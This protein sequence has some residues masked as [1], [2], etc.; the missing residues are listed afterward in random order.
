MLPS[1]LMTFIQIFAISLSP[2][3]ATPTSRDNFFL[4]E[5]GYCCAN[6]YDNYTIEPRGSGPEPLTYLIKCGKGKPVMRC[7]DMIKT[8]VSGKKDGG[9]Y[10]I[11]EDPEP[12]DIN[13]TA[14]LLSIDGLNHKG[15]LRLTLHVFVSWSSGAGWDESI[16]K[17]EK[18]RTNSCALF[19]NRTK[20]YKGFITKPEDTKIY[21]F[22]LLNDT[23]GGMLSQKL[24]GNPLKVQRDGKVLWI[25]TAHLALACYMDVSAF[26]FDRQNCSIRW[27]MAPPLPHVTVSFANV[28]DLSK[29]ANHSEWKTESYRCE[30][31][32]Y[33]LVMRR[34]AIPT[35]ST[36]L[37]PVVLFDLL[38]CLVYL[39]P[40]SSGE[41]VGFAVTMVL[42]FSV[43]ITTIN[44]KVPPASG[45]I[46]MEMLVFST[47]GKSIVAM[48]ETIVVIFLA[49]RYEKGAGDKSA[50][51]SLTELNKVGALEYKAAPT[52]LTELNKV[53]ALG[54]KA[55]PM[56]R[57]ELNK[58]GVSIAEDEEK[59]LAKAVGDG[60]AQ[61][62]GMA[63]IEMTQAN[64]ME[65]N[66]MA[67][68]NGLTE[69]EMTKANGM[70]EKETTQ[71]SGDLGG[72]MNQAVIFRGVGVANGLA[73]AGDKAARLVFWVDRTFLV[74][75]A[76]TTIVVTVN[77]LTAMN[78]IS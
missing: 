29:T 66:G 37:V 58:V 47:F 32:T 31:G 6:M 42:S 36:L 16:C 59:D 34:N 52:S 64:G 75:N 74:V 43:L 55:A 35:L 39:L 61:A 26:P 24:E 11:E 73:E 28:D 67:L 77:S 14:N 53:G 63:K 27:R 2:G 23:E 76:I 5:E 44:N 49:K 45:T 72:G 12:L 19:V 33:Y 22:F 30:N 18:M 3:K 20:K 50:S 68:G 4:H 48:V 51:T 56:S 60:K 71:A 38:G 7:G 21:D 54:Y 41:R 78:L 8:R 69:E 1:Q 17:N 9:S 10:L 70:A 57:T 40:S 13:F 46:A 62:D 25:G 15:E 65:E